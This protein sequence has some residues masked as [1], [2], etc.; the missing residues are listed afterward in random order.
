MTLK[1]AAAR[2]A[3][4]RQPVDGIGFPLVIAWFLPTT[5]LV[6]VVEGQIFVDKTLKIN[7]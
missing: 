7:Q 2:R 6:A 3:V 5:M 1:G 4:L